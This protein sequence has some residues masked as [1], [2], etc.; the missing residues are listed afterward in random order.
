MKAKY[1]LA[2]K[3]DGWKIVDVTVLGTGG[4]SMLADIRKDQVKPLLEK[5]GLDGLI[6]LMQDRLASLKK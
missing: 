3:A 6:K 1:D 2:K 5:N 4:A